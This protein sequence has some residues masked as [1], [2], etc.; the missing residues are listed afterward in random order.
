MKN[1][2]SDFVLNSGKVVRVWDNWYGIWVIWFAPVPKI[3]KISFN[4]IFIRR[5]R[6]LNRG[7]HW[8]RKRRK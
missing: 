7:R 8:D 5:F 4:E 3:L 6:G 1:Q 2:S